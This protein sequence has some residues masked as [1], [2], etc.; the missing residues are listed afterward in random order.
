MVLV[1]IVAC[2]GQIH[3]PGL[4]PERGPPP[5]APEVTPDAPVDD[6]TPDDLDPEHVASSLDQAPMSAIHRLSRRELENTVRDVFGIEG[7]VEDYMPADTLEPFDTVRER[8]AS[9]TFIDGLHSLAFAL[10]EQVSGDAAKLEELAGCTPAGP[11]DESCMRALATRLGLRLFR[12]PLQAS[13]ADALVANALAFATERDN[14]AVGARLV[15]ASLMQQPESVY[16]TEIGT[17]TEGVHRLTGPEVISK[18]AYL[19]WGTTPTEELLQRGQAELTPEEI[20]GLADEMLADPRAEAQMLEFHTLWLGVHELRAP[21]ELEASMRAETEQLLLRT[22]TDGR[23]WS[24]LFTS[25]NTFV[26][27]ALASH[28]GIDP[29]QDAGFVDYVHAER[30]GVLS[31]GSFLSL[32]RRNG[33]DTSPTQRGKYIAERLLCRTIPRPPPGVDVDNPP[34]TTE[35]ECKADGYQAHS[36]QGTSCYGCHQL[37]DPIGFGLERFDGLGQYRT[38]ETG[39]D[40]CTISGEGEVDGLGAFNGPRE[41]A[42]LLTETGEVMTCAVVQYLFFARGKMPA[43]ADRY[44]VARLAESFVDSG[45][46]F[47]GLV[48]AVVSDPTF[49]T[50]VEEP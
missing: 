33:G 39:S 47:R 19:I 42:Q 3:E 24:E 41:L 38:M 37:M 36:E 4:T 49:A 8:A 30:A 35:T 43:L 9:D 45:E 46:D 26:D 15:I 31:H 17:P 40:R 20:S 5:L 2:E 28:Y 23:P 10:A 11:A 22:L 16:R 18:L 25:T 13:E 14:F 48:R 50:R 27:A 7:L 21:S 44:A 32:V 34:A 6:W 29:P 1:G 12:R